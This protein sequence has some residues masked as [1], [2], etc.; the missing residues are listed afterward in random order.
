[1]SSCPARFKS[2]WLVEGKGHFFSAGA[3]FIGFCHQPEDGDEFGVYHI[4][5]RIDAARF[6]P[7]KQSIIPPHHAAAAG[8]LPFGD[9]IRIKIV[10]FAGKSHVRRAV[11]YLPYGQ[12]RYIEVA[13]FAQKDAVYIENDF[14]HDWFLRGNRWAI[15]FIYSNIFGKWEE[16]FKG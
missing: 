7:G 4:P 14:F 13:F 12:S 15:V 2:C 10:A 11:E 1:M 9:T 3:F 6:Q 5:V 8:D 16:G